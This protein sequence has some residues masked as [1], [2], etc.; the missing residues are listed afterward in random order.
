MLSR[1]KSPN[2]TQKSLSQR[3]L[4]ILGILFFLMYLVLGLMIIFWD[5]LPLAIS[6]N[7][8]IGLGALL[9]VYSFFRFIRLLQKNRDE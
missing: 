5:E 8:R 6:R 3:F 2:K 9:I 1:E 7:G 4:F